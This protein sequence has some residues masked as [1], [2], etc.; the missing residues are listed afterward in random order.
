[1]IQVKLN[2]F[3]KKNVIKKSI[4]LRWLK[5]PR[6][7]FSSKAKVHVAKESYLNAH[8]MAVR[9]TELIVYIQEIG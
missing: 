9:G 4:I 2:S 6:I 1:M 8:H 5:Q 7:L 3:I